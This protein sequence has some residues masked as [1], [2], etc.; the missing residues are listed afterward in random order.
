MVPP[1][2]PRAPQKQPQLPALPQ[3]PPA[4]TGGE[5]EVP[6]AGGLEWET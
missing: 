2:G 6:V 3:A 1:A 5:G 4:L